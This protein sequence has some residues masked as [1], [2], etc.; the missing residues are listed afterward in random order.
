L[1]QTA[2]TGSFDE[3]DIR[4]GRVT[5]VAEART[6]KPT[7]RLTIDF[8]IELGTK[9][10]C[11]AYRNYAADDL[12][13]RLVVAVVNLGPKQMGPEISEVLVLGVTNLGGGTTY[14]TTASEVPVGAEVS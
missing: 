7:Y 9:V 10:S 6:R 8:G 12:A 13:G 4:I 11:G 2:L 3:L 1:K 5:A 14:L